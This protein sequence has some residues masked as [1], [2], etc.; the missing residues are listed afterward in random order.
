MAVRSEVF[1][2]PVGPVIAKSPR[3][4]KSISISSAKLARPRTRS[5]LGRIERLLVEPGKELGHVLGQLGISNFPV[6]A[7]QQLGRREVGDGAAGGL[8]RGRRGPGSR[9]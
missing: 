1:P 5:L 2:A 7:P 3:F 8:W 9:Q 6:V 4:S